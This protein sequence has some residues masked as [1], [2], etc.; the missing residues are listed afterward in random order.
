ML[1]AVTELSA[2]VSIRLQTLRDALEQ[3]RLPLQLPN[4]EAAREQQRSSVRQI[5]DYIA[6]R[7]Q[8]LDAPLLAVVGGSTGAGKSTLVNSIVGHPVTRAGAIRPTT[9]QPILLHAPADRAWFASDRILPGLARITGVRQS[10]PLP[11]DRAGEDPDA[12]LIGSVVLLDEG[13]VPEQLALLDA[14]DV[15]SIADENRALAAQLLAAADLW[16]FVTTANRYADAVPWRLLEDAAGRDITVGVVLNRVPP[17]AAGEIESDLRQ[18]LSE[19][20]LARAP[21]FVVPETALD[22]LGLLDGSLV[23]PVRAWLEQ[24]AADRASRHEIARRTVAGAAAR[25]TAAARELAQARQEQQEAAAALHEDI[26]AVYADA[27]E[28]VVASTK[29]GSLLRGEVLARWQDYLG[30][31]DV[32]RTFEHWFG[33]VRDRA[34][35]FVQGRPQPIREVETEIE[36]G[37]HAIIVDQAQRAAGTSFQQLRQSP[38]GRQL[39]LEPGLGRES[40]ALPAA[41]SAAIRDW[42]GALL[43]LIHERAAG[44]RSRARLVSLGLNAVTVTLMVVLFASTG[45][46][47]GGEIAIAG[48]SAVVGQRLLE[49]IFGEE[50]VRQLAAEAR[51]DLEQR[52]SALFDREQDR[53]DV[54]LE[55]VTA[56]PTAEELRAAAAGLEQALR[57][58]EPELSSPRAVIT[59][60]PEVEADRPGSAGADPTSVD[61]PQRATKSVAAPGAVGAQLVDPVVVEHSARHEGETGSARTEP[62]A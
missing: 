56:G 42:Q 11:A 30:T 19:R 17:A 43:Q 51:T 59:S 37:L 35:A 12:A 20:G 15:D 3:L 32:F 52:V 2:G 29:D 40:A 60:L 41:A 18:L 62:Q 21:L 26:S 46:L 45:G 50:A 1:G 31:S 61:D 55:P 58:G 6:P 5:D 22:E 8:N 34:T 48:G 44:K 39:A 4:A 24:L 25:L 7:L 9:R 49:T 23:T 57:V 53:F 16:L 28:R 38:A 36:H 14:P 47:T 27:R 54:L 33:R 13:R 10:T